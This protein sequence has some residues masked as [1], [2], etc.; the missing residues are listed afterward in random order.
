MNDSIMEMTGWFILMLRHLFKIMTS[1]DRLFALSFNKMDCYY[2]AIEIIQLFICIFRNAMINEDWKVTLTHMI[3]CLEAILE[4]QKSLLQ[5]ESLDFLCLARFSQD[6]IENKFSNICIQQPKLSA[7]ECKNCLKQLA[8]SRK[9]VSMNNSSYNFDGATTLLN[10][11]SRNEKPKETDTLPEI[12][13][14]QLHEIESLTDEEEEI[15]YK[16]CGYIVFKLKK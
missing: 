16:M 7:L 11:I 1:R 10:I 2:T 13:L 3:V 4:I 14:P 12:I 9:A 5:V 6:C 8:I 15:L